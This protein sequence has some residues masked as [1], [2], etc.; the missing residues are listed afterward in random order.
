MG[1]KLEK[2]VNVKPCIP[3]EDKEELTATS[4]SSTVT[5]SP[6]IQEQ[7]S[8]QQATPSTNNRIVL[9]IQASASPSTPRSA[10]PSDM[11]DDPIHFEDAVKEEKWVVAMEE[12]IEAIE[13]NETWELVS[14]PKGKHVIG[15]KWVYNTKSNI[16]GKIERHKARLVFKGYK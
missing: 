2:T 14:L 5:P 1:W 13:R 6:P 16:E 15:V 3:H 8:R 12:E 9:R 10:T 7:Q 11:S 4:N